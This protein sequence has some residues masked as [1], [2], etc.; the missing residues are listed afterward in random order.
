MRSLD[1]FL[2]AVQAARAAARWRSGALCSQDASARGRNPWNVPARNVPTPDTGEPPGAPRE[3]RGR[4]LARGRGPSRAHQS[5]NGS[6]GGGPARDQGPKQLFLPRTRNGAPTLRSAAANHSHDPAAR[7]AP[8]RKETNGRRSCCRRSANQRLSPLK[9]EE[10]S[11]LPPARDPRPRCSFRPCGAFEPR[12]WRC[13]RRR[14]LPS[15]A[16]APPCCPCHDPTAR[17]GA[18]VSGPALRHVP[19]P[20]YAGDRRQRGGPGLQVRAGRGR[21]AVAVVAGHRSRLVGRP[22]CQCALRCPGWVAGVGSAGVAGSLPRCCS[23][24]GARPGPLHRNRLMV[25]LFV[26]QGVWQ[27]PGL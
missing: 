12:S 18:A 16:R 1:L 5:E 17:R 14:P 9:K 19:P 8:R 15:S 4:D 2:D 3:R 7:P 23:R 11:P 24:R 10:R 27:R 20:C 21:E 25:P 13:C 22:S 6:A 26:G